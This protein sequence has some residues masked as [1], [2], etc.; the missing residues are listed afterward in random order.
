MVSPTSTRTDRMPA[1]T[2]ARRHW[3]GPVVGGFYLSMGGVHLGLVA[4]DT[5]AYRHFADAGLFAFVRDG[6]QEVFM[7]H[8]TTFGLLLAAG[9]T[10]LGILLL[11]G[12]RCATVGW[13]GVITFHLLLMLFGFGVWLWCLPALALLVHL[14]RRDTWTSWSGSDPI[15]AYERSGHDHADA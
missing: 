14:A 12:G 15:D 2:T 1:R 11:L 3:G 7:A 13:A 9:E 10:A 4:A 6:W 5:E 8:P